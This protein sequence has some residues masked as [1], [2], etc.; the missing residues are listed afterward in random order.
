[1]SELEYLTDELKHL[2]GWGATPHRLPTH[3]PT[4]RELVDL[5]DCPSEHVAGLVMQR[6][7]RAAI[8]SLSGTYEI[9][10]RQYSAET[11]NRVYKLCF[12]FE[13]PK[14]APIRRTRVLV[15]L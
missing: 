15:L 1:M 8:D 6:R 12:W 9:W 13:G 7:L 5:S 4:L 11:L 2:V 10:G 14:E 3:A